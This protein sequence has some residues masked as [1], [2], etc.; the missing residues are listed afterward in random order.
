MAEKPGVP[1]SCPVAEH[2]STLAWQRLGLARRDPKAVEILREKRKSATYLLA[3]VGEGGGDVIAKCGRN[4]L[5]GPDLRTVDAAFTR[6]IPWSR[7]GSAGRVELRLEVFNLFNRA[8]FGP[9]ALVA[10]NGTA[11]DEDPLPSFGQIRSTVTS[12]RQVQLG[13]RIVF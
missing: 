10:F 11:A 1:I 12:A 5:I 9:P 4:E 2:R 8:N 3:G 7:L 6:I 13:A